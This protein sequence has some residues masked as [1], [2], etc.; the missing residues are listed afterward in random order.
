MTYNTVYPDDLQCPFCN[1][2]VTSGV[3]FRFGCLENKNYK[4]GEKIN[5]EG[6]VHRPETRP[7]GGNIKSVGYFNCDNVK[8]K[9]WSDCF[10]DVQQALITVKN[11]VIEKVE[12]YKGPLSGEQFEIIE[13]VQGGKQ[14]AR[15]PKK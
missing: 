9:S 6:A 11:D 12:V 13:P 15:S 8:C 10:P 1:E 3:G 5:W 2:K 7:K 4:P 14:K